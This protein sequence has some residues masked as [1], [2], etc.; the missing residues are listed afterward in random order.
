[1][2]SIINT[3]WTMPT[4]WRLYV[5][6]SAVFTTTATAGI[7]IVGDGIVLGFFLLIAAFVKGAY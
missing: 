5:G 1:M 2:Q 3:L 7:G 6:A 4:S